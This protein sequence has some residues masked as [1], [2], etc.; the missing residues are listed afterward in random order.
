MAKEVSARPA[1]T[2]VSLIELARS[3]PAFL[4]WCRNGLIDHMGDLTIFEDRAPTPERRETLESRA[5]QLRAA[6]APSFDGPAARM[7]LT[8]L[9]AMPAQSG[10][11]ID[12][13]MRGDAF[14]IALRDLPA[15]A[16]E[17]E[18][19]RV[20]RG[21]SRLGARFAPTPAEFREAISDSLASIRVEL[22][23]IEDVLRARIIPPPPEHPKLP[24]TR[25]LVSDAAEAPALRSYSEVM[26]KDLAERK[27]K[28]EA[29][30]RS[31]AA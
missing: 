4:G 18:A 20:I 7:V 24:P 13:E 2:A 15:W 14:R 8:M 28:R 11:E 22:R 5:S 6:L 12:T 16:I 19:T 1:A 31:E 21:E 3:R 9:S 26:L 17:R 30:A 23:Q 10:G 25:H 29:E 27:A